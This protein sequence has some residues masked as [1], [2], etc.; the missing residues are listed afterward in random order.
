MEERLVTNRKAPML[1]IMIH[2]RPFVA[3]GGGG[4]FCIGLTPGGG[5]IGVGR[6]FP[7]GICPGAGLVVVIEG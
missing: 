2:T 6:S 4:V 1:D 5:S 3:G 7:T